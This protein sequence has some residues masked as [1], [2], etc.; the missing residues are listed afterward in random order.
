MSID[1]SEQTEED[2]SRIAALR[3]DEKGGV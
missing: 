3:A 2:K 1:G